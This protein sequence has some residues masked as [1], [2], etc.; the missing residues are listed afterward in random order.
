MMALLNVMSDSMLSP[1]KCYQ[2]FAS[3]ETGKKGKLFQPADFHTFD[4]LLL[5]EESV[6]ACHQSDNPSVS[7]HATGRIPCFLDQF[8]QFIPEA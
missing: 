2:H 6:K 3:R 8:V 5:E 7:T 1:T 4:Q